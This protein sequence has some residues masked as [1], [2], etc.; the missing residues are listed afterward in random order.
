[1]LMHDS[2]SS[3][4]TA[5]DG[6]GAVSLANGSTAG[7]CT[8]RICS[9]LGSSAFASSISFA[10]TM[11]IGGSTGFDP[12]RSRPLTWTSIIC[13]QVKYSTLANISSRQSVRISKRSTLYFLPWPQYAR[14][15]EHTSELQSQ[16]NLVCRLLLE[17]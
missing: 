1:M 9:T 4:A 5:T 6:T 2:S 12:L 3:C 7:G 14:S 8:S 10:S 13:D 11:R 15:E 16:S 17:K